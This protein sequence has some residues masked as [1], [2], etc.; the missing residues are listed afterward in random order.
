MGDI[1]VVIGKTLG[2]TKAAVAGS[3]KTGVLHAAAGALGAPLGVLAVVA[4]AAAGSV[5]LMDISCTAAA[6]A[7]TKNKNG[8]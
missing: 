3:A 7:L 6:K 2:A 5:I 8:G 4:V 1:E